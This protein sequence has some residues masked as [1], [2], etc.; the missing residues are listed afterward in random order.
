MRLKIISDSILSPKHRIPRI[1]CWH[2]H[3]AD[4]EKRSHL[5]DWWFDTRFRILCVF[6]TVAKRKRIPGLGFRNRKGTAGCRESY[7]F[8][9]IS[10][11]SRSR[12][13]AN[14]LAIFAWVK[15]L[16]YVITKFERERQISLL[17]TSFWQQS[18]LTF[19]Y[20]KIMSIVSCSP[21][22][23]SKKL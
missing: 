6:W 22:F 12:Q 4:W 1:W 14:T 15:S 9:Y 3:L 17:Y 2:K 16:R 18:F 19:L 21:S 10:I 13:S 20:N 8:I 7:R 11:S 5:F 23:F